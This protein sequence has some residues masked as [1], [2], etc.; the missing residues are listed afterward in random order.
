Q[1]G[2]GS[3]VRNAQ[4]PEPL[5]ARLSHAQHEDAGGKGE[6]DRRLRRHAGAGRDDLS[7][8][9]RQA[10]VTRQAAFLRGVN[11]GKRT[12]RSADLV[13]AFGEMGFS[14]AKTLIASGN[15]LFDADTEKNLDEQYV[16]ACDQ[17]F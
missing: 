6:E 3:N 15:V 8:R 11:L 2:G 4:S 9:Q 7:Q 17:R 12:V 10:K 16:A 13:A 1:S 14:N 5:L